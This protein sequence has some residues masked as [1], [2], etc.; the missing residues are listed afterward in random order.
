MHLVVIISQILPAVVVDCSNMWTELK[1]TIHDPLFI[2]TVTSI[3][4]VIV[5]KNPWLMFVTNQN[6]LRTANLLINL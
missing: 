4:I 1:G 6:Q 5:N 2:H 3:K